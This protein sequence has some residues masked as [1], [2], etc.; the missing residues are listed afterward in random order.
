MSHV[1]RKLERSETKSDQLLSSPPGMS[2]V[3]YK[4]SYDDFV[5]ERQP[6][7][8]TSHCWTA[9]QSIYLGCS[10]GQLL[11]VDFESGEVIVLTNPQL[12]QVSV[13]GVRGRVNN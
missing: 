8:L 12:A 13:N 5:R 2:R 11:Q 6:V 7:V 1:G 3:L 10:G 4:E 9:Q